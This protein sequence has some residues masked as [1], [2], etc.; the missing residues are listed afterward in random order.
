MS[1]AN[2]FIAIAGNPNSG[3]TTAFNWYTG[4]RQHVGNY[5]GITVEKKEGTATIDGNSV[6]LIDL[7]G[8]YSLTAYSLEEVVAR[9]VLSEDRPGAVLNVVNA[10]V[11]ERNLY[12][13]VQMLE[14]GVPVV[15]ALNMMDEARAQ[16][17]EINIK[18]LEE[19]M[20]VKVVSTVARTGEG[21]KEALTEALKLSETQSGTD[22][23]PLEI[24]YGPDVDEA[25]KTM[26]PLVEQANF[27]TAK[28]PARWIALKFLEKD[29]DIM[30]QGLAASA[31]ISA[32][33]QAIADKLSAHLKTTLNTYPEGVIADYRYGYI[34]S[35]LR[36]GVV[37]GT[38][39]LKDRL[40]YSD[41]MDMVLTNRL[42]G[43]V[44]LMV[45]LYAM[46]YV[47]FELGAYPAD[48]L[49]A[50]F[51]W[52]HGA[53]DAALPD[54][55]LKSMITSG[56]I[57]GVG[58]V[59]GFVPL[60]MIMFLFIT[61]LEDSGYMAR[62]AYMMDRIFRIFGL[63]GA[64]IMPFI[65]AGGIAGGCAIPAVM[66]TRTLRSPRERLAT[67]L[68]APFMACGA[69]LPVFL[70]FVGIF[71]A[72][73]QAEVM[74]MLTLAGWASA[75]LVARLL[76]STIIKGE[77][78]PFVMELPP[79]RL[80]TL[81]GI[82]IHTWERAWQYMKKAG[83]IILAISILLWAA[84]TYPGLPE[85]AAQGFADKK[86]PLEEQLSAFPSKKLSDEIEALKGEIE[87]LP[88]TDSKAKEAQAKI[89]PLQKELEELPAGK[90]QAE[91]DDLT[92]QL[93][94]IGE[95]AKADELK[96]RIEE[97]TVAFDRLKP[98]DSAAKKL[99]A[100]IDKL[101]EELE[102]TPKGKIEADIAKLQAEL[103]ALPEKEL[104]AKIAEISNEEASEA[105]R[106]S[107]AGRLGILMEPVTAP[108]GFDWRTNIALVGGIAAK[109]VVV[110][111]L[112]TAY[113]LG[114]IDEDNESTLADRIKADKNWTTANAIAL[115]LFTL[116]YS[117]CFVTLAVIKNESG[118][119][120][121]LFFSL[122]F[123]LGLAYAVAVAANQIVLRM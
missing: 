94:K 123:N 54:G 12:L 43:P 107:Y 31:D 36:Q 25:L 105:L 116:L 67:M 29:E 100:E 39:A 2:K 72:D 55:L 78:T 7:P 76:R 99:Q 68:T 114:E 122:F 47:T 1:A 81:S 44:I 10:G 22:W 92:G 79:Y 4:A 3:K 61:F 88:E 97:H 118:S 65:V 119:W 93:E 56:V 32:K 60:I 33:L 20:G 46:Y 87:G 121:W 91:I 85:D 109:E 110:A 62:V 48:L 90:L 49:A 63:H 13:T 21:L 26:T 77:A 53:A 69:K 71:F 35:I 41:K 64:S 52:L 16:G 104:E 82:L 37:K 9:R 58:G 28:Y 98:E 18:R 40:A 101:T 6:S 80:P 42:F 70:L 30:E 59:I 50:G 96:A 24:S 120:K 112:G 117:P 51:E 89:D 8:T 17:I 84:M 45:I 102:N 19:L 103:D 83:T 38:D 95:D 75:L 15:L 113:S 106:S 115:L 73:H 86:A 27:L 74:F 11:L 14:M 108:A 111:T 23:K 34:S 57:D 5:P 66:A